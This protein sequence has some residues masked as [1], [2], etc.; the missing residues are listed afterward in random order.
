MRRDPARSPTSPLVLT[1][2]TPDIQPGPSQ[3]VTRPADPAIDKALQLSTFESNYSAEDFVGTLSEKLID[4]SKATSGPFDPQPFMDTFSPA[5]DSL[6]KLREQVA[7]R[8]KR[9]EMDVRRAER[10]YG[11]RLRELDG[12]FEVSDHGLIR[13]RQILIPQAIGSSFSNLESKISDVGRT[14]VRI[15]EQLESLHQTR[16]TA[17]STAL[18][19]SYYLSLAHQTSMTPDPNNPQSNPLEA[20]FATRTSREG[21]SRLAVILRRLMSVAK[22][23]ADNASTALQDAEAAATPKV[24]GEAADATA[25]KTVMRRRAEKEKAERVRDEVEK[26]CEK[27]E[28]EVLRL[29]DRSYR[30]GDPRMMAVS[31]RG[32]VRD[33]CSWWQ[34][35]AKTLQDFNGGASCVQIYV[36]QHDFFISKDRIIE[37]AEKQDPSAADKAD[38]RVGPRIRRLD[39]LTV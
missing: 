14:A 25:G 39:L 29:F 27:F 23:V 5:L 9:M 32:R 24:G 38:M 33:F 20:L 26:Y 30:K 12:G 36:N 35:C 28:K 3:P 18:L 17:Q 19:L 8:T 37:E 15:G 6:L 2:S 22:D 7:E 13:A 4:R 11:R 21:R 16:S 1:L 34:H 10:E 31:H